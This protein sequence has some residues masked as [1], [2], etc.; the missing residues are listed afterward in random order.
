[1]DV[2]VARDAAVLVATERYVHL[3]C[4]NEPRGFAHLVDRATGGAPAKQHGGRAAQQLQAIKVEGVAVI[5]GGV[6][7]AVNEHVTGALQRK[8]AQTNV[9]LSAFRRQERDAS[10][11]L[12]GF[13]DGVQ[14]AVIDQA[15][16]D[17]CDGL[18]N[19]TQLLLAFADGGLCGA[20]AVLALGGF[21][22]FL[23]C[24]GCEGFFGGRGSLGLRANGSRQYQCTQR[25][26]SFFG[27]WWGLQGCA[28]AALSA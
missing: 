17:H 27:W 7:H 6:A 15:L 22:A 21:C 2:E 9:F 25:Q 4:I 28:A 8:A 5:E 3:V 12:Q 13:L 20:H 19:V 24:H 1:M 11:V 16:G 14:I 10:G 26:E 23:H 18:R